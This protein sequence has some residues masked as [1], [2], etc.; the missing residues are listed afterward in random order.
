MSFARTSYVIR[1]L[2]IVGC[3][4]AVP[5]IVRAAEKSTEAVTFESDVQPLLTRLG[6]NAGPCHGK[7][8]GQNGFALSL[9]GFDSDFDYAALV[10]EAR[11]RRV[12]AAAPEESLLLRK[13]VGQLPHGGGKRF[14][15]GSPPYEQI[16]AWI[17]DGAPRTPADAPKLVRVIAEPASQ[18]L[19]PQQQFPLR[20]IAEYSDG[21][22][23]DVTDGAAFQSNDRTIAA[24]APAG[25]GIVQAGPV[26]GEAAIMARY[27]NHIAVCTVTIPLPGNVPDA[28]YQQLPRLSAIDD[29]VWQKLKLLGMTPSPPAND[30][31]FHRRAF[32]R[33][34]GRLPTPDETRAYLAD[35]SP[36]KREA[37]V[38]GLLDRP[39]YADFWANKWA[40][41]LRPNPYRAGIKSVW[42]LDAWLRDAFRKNMPYDQFV[43]EL[44]TAQGSTWKNGATVIFRDRPEPI[45]IGASVSQL[46]LGVRLE[47]AKCHHHPFEVW[48]QDD[49]FGFASFFSRIG[50]KGEGLS[51]P[52]SGGEEMI[53]TKSS[54]QL[55]HGHTGQPVA[56]KTLTGVPLTFGPDEDPREALVAWMTDSSNHYFPRVMANR[57]WAEI[58]G[59]GLVDPVDDIR[60]TNPA[61]NEI[62]LDHLANEFRQNGY[63]IKKLI[64]SIMTTHVFRLSSVPNDRN[65]SDVKNFS[66]YYRRRMRAEILLDAVNDVLESEEEFAATP[67]G[68]RAMQ[69]W[70]FRST[71]LFLDTFGRPDLNQDPPCERSTETTTPQA[72]HLMNSPLLNK[73]IVLDTSRPAKLAASDWTNEAIVD[74]AYLWAY[75]RLPRDE[76]RRAAVEYLP[77]AAAERRKAVEDLFWALLNTPEFSFVD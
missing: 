69:M 61:T 1:S 64:R 13:A 5:A 10:R 28:D 63:D 43:R 29:L 21:H 3:L 57:V 62:L 53:F 72:L 71:S 45:E 16:R 11:G 22:R 15:I 23:R 46:F 33:A 42:N 34:I 17:H 49:F 52:I 35:Q 36:N 66:R 47:C 44:L 6:C 4:S 58:M 30:A 60:A 77:A 12:F 40:D 2:V 51:P 20:V 50:H 38:D 73:K 8:R 68:S 75:S 37:L 19:A 27:M 7:S 32:V 48:S 14:E 65:I 41:L 59:Q 67:P 56:P 25:D 31:T 18:S 74:E 39:E 54:G 26:P 55:L 24:I 76:E 9:L 70:T